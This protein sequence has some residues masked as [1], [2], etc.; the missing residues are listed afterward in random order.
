MGT[1]LVPVDLDVG[2]INPKFCAWIQS[3]GDESIVEFESALKQRYPVLSPLPTNWDL[4]KELLQ[5]NN[6]VNCGLELFHSTKIGTAIHMRANTVM[7]LFINVVQ[8]YNLFVVHSDEI[9]SVLDRVYD[10]PKLLICENGDEFPV[11][12]QCCILCYLLKA[13]FEL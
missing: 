2:V 11:N 7:T 12:M 4:H 10:T 8:S 1:N 13:R 3:E 5:L 9:V 6:I